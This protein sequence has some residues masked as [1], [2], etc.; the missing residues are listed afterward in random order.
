MNTETETQKSNS[1][2]EDLPRVMAHVRDNIMPQYQAIGP[3][4][5]FALAMMRRDLDLAAKA[6]AEGDVVAMLAVYQSLKEYE[7]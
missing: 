5:G 3:A 2:G 1:L 6:M 4:G 7:T